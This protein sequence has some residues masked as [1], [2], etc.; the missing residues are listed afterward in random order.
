MAPNDTHFLACVSLI[1]Q[2][3]NAA[4]SRLELPFWYRAHAHVMFKFSPA[5]R[6]QWQRPSFDFSIVQRHTL[7][8]LRRHF[9][10]KCDVLQMFFCLFSMCT[11]F[12]SRT[13]LLD[14]NL[15]WDFSA[16]ASEDTSRPGLVWFLLL[17]KITDLK[18]TKLLLLLFFA[19]ST[20]SVF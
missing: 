5:A 14:G 6:R 13:A 19:K 20:G 16:T 3:Y 12:R 4:L 10:Q 15:S 11:F 1:S 18:N 7:G 9:H 17:V 8:S 2:G